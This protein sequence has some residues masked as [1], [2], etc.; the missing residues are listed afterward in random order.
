MY[1]PSPIVLQ[2]RTVTIYEITSGWR[3]IE[4]RINDEA[5]NS[6]ST[7]N[8]RR[9]RTAKLIT[10]ITIQYIKGEIIPRI[11]LEKTTGIL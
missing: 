1:V 9:Q 5:I 7:F 6:H 11:T 10:T 3:K 4:S 2:L 8:T